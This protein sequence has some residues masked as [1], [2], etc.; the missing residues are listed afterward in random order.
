MLSL[1]SQSFRQASKRLVNT[2]KVFNIWKDHEDR[3]KLKEEE[4]H[5]AMRNSCMGGS[6]EIMKFLLDKNAYGK[7]VDYVS[8]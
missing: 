8:S 2:M 5:Q 1:R 3:E 7:A 6:V 4:L